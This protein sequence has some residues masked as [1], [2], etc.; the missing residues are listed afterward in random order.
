MM[1]SMGFA[2][3]ALAQG[4]ATVGYFPNNIIWG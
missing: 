3:F 2:N 1:V 4:L